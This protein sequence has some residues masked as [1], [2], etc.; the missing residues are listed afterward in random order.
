MCQTNLIHPLFFIRVCELL[1]ICS[2][3]Y[4]TRTYSAMRGTRGEIPYIYSILSPQ[5]E[6][7]GST[8]HLLNYLVL[9]NLVKYGYLCVSLP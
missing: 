6:A 4:E 3:E 9:N 8:P 1:Y 5:S 7:V 2:T